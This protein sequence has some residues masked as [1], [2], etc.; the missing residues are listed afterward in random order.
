MLLKGGK[1]NA[2]NPGTYTHER[3]AVAMS[4]IHVCLYFKN[5]GGKFFIFGFNVF[6]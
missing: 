1:N 2:E 4:G 5:E 6:T 3:N